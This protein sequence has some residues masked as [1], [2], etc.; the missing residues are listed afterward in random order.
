MSRPEE[1]N[2]RLLL[3]PSSHSFYVSFI[4]AE[5]N[6]ISWTCSSSPPDYIAIHFPTTMHY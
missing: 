4:W 1:T 3:H 2:R 5:I 6:F